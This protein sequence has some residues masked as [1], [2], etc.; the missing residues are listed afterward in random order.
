MTPVIYLGLDVSQ[1]TLQN[2]L[3]M[4]RWTPNEMF[5]ILTMWA[6][7][8]MQPPMLGD[9]KRMEL[10][11]ELAK[12]N[13]PVM[14]FDTLRDFFGG[15]ENSS[16]ETKPVVDAIRKLRAAGATP[17]L[18]VHPPKSGKSIIRGTGNISQKVDIPYLL[19]KDKWRGKEIAVFTCP[20]KNR[21][22][23]TSFRM[24]MQIQCIPMPAGTFLRI[25]EART[26][27]HRSIG[28]KEKWMKL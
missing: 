13:H 8:H 18:L 19:E 10:L 3:R 12:E 27:N 17:L 24:P 22:G 9:P 23:S 14:V 4:M 26:G 15:E 11:Y 28:K 7:E 20:K 6:G 25:R 5:R 16:T 2:Y 21:F 1:V